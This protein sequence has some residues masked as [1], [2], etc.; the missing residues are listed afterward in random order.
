MKIQIRNS[1]VNLVAVVLILAACAAEITTVPTDRVFTL[2]GTLGAERWTSI[3]V[4]GSTEPR[5]GTTLPAFLVCRTSEGDSQAKAAA[6]VDRGILTLRGD[7]T[8]RLELTAGTWWRNGAVVGGS[9]GTISEFGRW[10]E[11]TPGTIHLSGFV[12]VAFKA[13]FHYT[14]AGSGLTSMTFSCP[15]GSGTE[16][17]TPELVFSRA[18]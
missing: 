3:D 9:G 11:P 12:T 2:V 18:R 4:P 1:A 15:G 7:G 5:P 10:S 14:E 13:P 17:L 6:V 8:S 16:S